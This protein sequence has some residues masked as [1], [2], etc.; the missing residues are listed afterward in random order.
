MHDNERETT[1]DGSINIKEINQFLNKIVCVCVSKKERKFCW[2]IGNE[3]ATGS[4]Q[5][6][7]LI[8]PFSWIR[9]VN[10]RWYRYYSIC[11]WKDNN[12]ISIYVFITILDS[13]QSI[14]CYPCCNSLKITYKLVLCP[15]FAC[16]LVIYQL[17]T[18]INEYHSYSIV[19]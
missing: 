4:I 7:K 17:Y 3:T 5:V 18:L 8:F 13:S 9:F 14:H 10:L 1:H 6:M 15:V 19:S 12:E 11:F 2:K 16:G